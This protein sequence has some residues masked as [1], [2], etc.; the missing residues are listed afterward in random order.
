MLRLALFACLAATS[1][2]AYIWPSPQLDALEEMRFEQALAPF[3]QPCDFFLRGGSPGH[4]GRSDAADWIRTA[5]HDMATHNATDGTGGMDGSIR[6]A[7]ELARP[8]NSGDGLQLTVNVVGDQ[9]NR[10]VSVADMLAIGLVIAVENCGGPEIAFRGGRVDALEPSP[11]GVPQPQDDLDSHIASFARQGFTQTEMIGLV[12]CGHTFGGVQHDP[13]PDIVPELTDPNSTE[14]VVHFDSSSVLFDNNVAIEYI[15]GSTQNP[16]VVGSNDTTNSDKRIFGSDGNVTMHS[17]SDSPDLFASTCA[18]LFARMIDTVPSGVQLTEVIHPL[19]VKPSVTK[20]ILAGE[21][22]QLSGSVRFWNL[23]GD[24]NHTVRML[25]DDH[26]GGTNNITM[27]AAGS[28][29]NSGGRHTG[30][31]YGFGPNEGNP[32]LA[33]NATAGITTMRFVVDD[34]LEDQG[35][36]GFALQDSVVLS[37]S[38]CM[39]LGNDGITGQL[40]V[41]VRK[42]VTPKQVYV[43]AEALDDTGRPIVQE[44][45]VPRP[46]GSEAGAPDTA[47]TMWSAPMALDGTFEIFSITADFEGTPALNGP[48]MDLFSLASCANVSSR[49]LIPAH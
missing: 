8:E 9:A 23:T 34:T 43:V 21:T 11:P 13:F 24:E 33:L 27:P 5:Y 7:E 6:F 10:Y 48:R 12:A 22:L 16:L 32:P 47:Y 38:S 18:E 30:A 39:D 15:S 3:V 44:I 14:S 17:F 36:L 49:A 29:S 4:T 20:F 2:R 35:G 42:G 28:F 46:S 41:A 25:W 1:T 40:D 19:H 37:A 31:F 45:D 26:F